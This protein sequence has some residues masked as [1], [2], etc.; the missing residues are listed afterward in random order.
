MNKRFVL[1]LMMIFALVLA[2][3]SDTKPND[4]RGC[5]D[6]SKY[7]NDRGCGPGNDI[8]SA[9]GAEGEHSEEGEHAEEGDHAEGEET[10]SEEGA[11]TEEHSEEG[12]AEDEHAE[13]SEAEHADEHSEAEP[14]AEAT[15]AA[16]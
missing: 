14:T 15:E 12:A 1:A 11:A 6:P 7:T 2:A 16:H 9:H 5:I 13:E 8:H 4:R 3:C 10:H